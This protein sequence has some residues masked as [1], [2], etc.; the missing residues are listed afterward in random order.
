MGD[1]DSLQQTISAAHKRALKVLRDEDAAQDF[2]IEIWN[3]VAKGKKIRHL[4][5]YIRL[6]LRKAIAR[7]YR[8]P[9]IEVL[10]CELSD[11]TEGDENY[12][13][14]DER[15]AQLVDGLEI[16]DE[17][18][19][20]HGRLTSYQLDI[21][22]MLEAGYSAP[23]IASLFDVYPRTI[24]DQINAMK[25]DRLNGSFGPTKYIA[26]STK[27]LPSVISHPVKN[28]FI[29]SYTR[30][31]GTP[32]Y[33]GK[34]TIRRV[35]S[36]AHSVKLPHDPGNVHILAKNLSDPDARQ[37]EM[38]LIYLY[39]RIDNR[40]G[41]LYN[42]TDGADG[43]AFNTKLSLSKDESF[44]AD[45]PDFSLIEGDGYWYSETYPFTETNPKPKSTQR[46]LK[47]PQP[48]DPYYTKRME[49][50]A[51][52]ERLKAEWQAAV[53]SGNFKEELRLQN[54]YMSS[55]GRIAA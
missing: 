2:A 42:K 41:C 6:R 29:Y 26:R 31:D 46:T 8:E 10:A 18:Y 9:N 43:A 20:D 16:E 44:Y 11:C 23:T 34:G 21:V 32:Y 27:L 47:F 22:H 3:D 15:L 38:L 1:K 37:A 53:T 45:N 17:S 12:L 25:E 24:Y 14:Q 19:K 50:R 51:E 36:D 4:G 7:K 40:T 13:E 52:A 30:L 54:A 39:G 28:R 49:E 55:K 33:I 5:G 48:V 35:Y